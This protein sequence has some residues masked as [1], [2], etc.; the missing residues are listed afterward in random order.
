MELVR[1]ET[2]RPGNTTLRGIARPTAALRRQIANL[3]G[4]AGC[5]D[6][7]RVLI[8]AYDVSLL[9]NLLAMAIALVG[10]NARA[11]A[12]FLTPTT[13]LLGRRAVLDRA[14][15][16][17]LRSHGPLNPYEVAEHVLRQ[18]RELEYGYE[19]LDCSLG[20]TT[21]SNILKLY[22]NNTTHA[23]VGDATGIVGS[24]TAGSLY[25]ETETAAPGETGT[26]ST[27][28]SAY[29]S[30]ARVAVARSSGGWTISGTSPT[31]AAN[32]GA[33]T[34]PAA[35]GGSETETNFGIGRASS[36][37]GELLWTGA[38]TSNLAVSNGIT[39]SFAAGA[40]VAT[41]D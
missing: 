19:R 38:L 3:Y 10:F 35:T 33:T 40:C 16:L 32:A 15:E 22:F 29:T 36:G 17:S 13:G 27:S 28:E 41:L 18:W 6:I 25:V 23:N 14:L 21:E 2:T 8:D 9:G 24:S 34:F 31:Q 7:R 20:D 12:L 1:L 26:Q 11:L 30:Y 5:R 4:S 37:T 39:P